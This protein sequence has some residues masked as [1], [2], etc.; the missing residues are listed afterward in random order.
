MRKL[1]LVL[2][3]SLGGCASL[4]SLRPGVE[5]VCTEKRCYMYGTQKQIDRHCRKGVVRWDDGTVAHPGDGRRSRCCTQYQPGRRIRIWVSRL[6]QS[7]LP[8]EECH[9]EEW[10]SGRGDHKRCDGFGVG[11]EKKRL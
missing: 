8:H 4:D 1:A 11:Q 6:D 3:L 2:L 10:Q 7:C 9:I 5:R